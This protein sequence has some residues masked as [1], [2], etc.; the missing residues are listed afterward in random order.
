MSCSTAWS[1]W[2]RGRPIFAIEL[3][4][5]SLKLITR[6]LDVICIYLSSIHQMIICLLIYY[7]GNVDPLFVEVEMQDCRPLNH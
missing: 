4:V 1:R 5:I 2:I 7:L 6:G 3:N